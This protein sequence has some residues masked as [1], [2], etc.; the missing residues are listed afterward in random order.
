VQSARE[1][2]NSGGGAGSSRYI[3][4]AHILQQAAPLSEGA[5]DLIR[6]PRVTSKQFLY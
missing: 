4:A 3:G 1:V 2:S 5:R 6:P